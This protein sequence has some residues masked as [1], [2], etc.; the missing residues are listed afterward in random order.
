MWEHI[1]DEFKEQLDLSRTLMVGDTLYTDIEF[2]NL[3]GISSLLVET[4]NHTREHVQNSVSKPLPIPTY[5]AKS[6][7]DAILA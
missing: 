1:E 4:G 3:R 5:I 6:L 7:K 2:A